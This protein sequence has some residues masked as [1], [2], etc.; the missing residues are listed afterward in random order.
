MSHQQ[1]QLIKEEGTLSQCLDAGGSYTPRDR[2]RYGVMTIF[3]V[4]PR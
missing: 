2:T 3:Y 4:A 1:E